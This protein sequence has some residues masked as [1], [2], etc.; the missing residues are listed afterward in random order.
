M[1]TSTNAGSL[2]SLVQ[3]IPKFDTSNNL[4]SLPTLSS[5]NTKP[6]EE[7]GFYYYLLPVLTLTFCF[8]IFSAYTVV[9]KI[10]LSDNTSPL[11]LA[12]LREVIALG[13]LMPYSW[14]TVARRPVAERKFWIEQEDAIFIIFLGLTMGFGVQVL[15]ALALK[16]IS[17]LNYAL[18][19]PSVPP[20]NLSIS[21]FTGYEYF[22]RH[23]R[24]SWLK[25]SGIII[26]VIGSIAVALT[27]SAEASKS[28]G[29]VI[30][31][32]ILLFG[33]KICIAIYPIIEKRLLKKGYDP[34]AIV[35]WGYL[36]GSSLTLLSIIPAIVLDCGGGASFNISFSGWIAVLYASILTSALN[37]SLM[38]SMEVNFHCSMKVGHGM[39]TFC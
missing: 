35:A 15:S 1:A 8:T 29:N 17:A 19:A 22:S 7:T 24:N 23:S 12:F 25:V 36:A 11:V 2:N 5:P 16:N 13:I 34:V 27:A 21:I 33:N 30:L 31:G 37:Y 9:V 32:N 28:G 3:D 14:I 10:A 38:V 20:M 6:K 26:S 4:P 18:L 39:Y